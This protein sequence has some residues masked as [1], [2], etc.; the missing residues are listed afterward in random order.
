MTLGKSNDRIFLMKTYII[1][2]TQQDIDKGI[3]RTCLTCPVAIAMARAT[4][5]SITVSR[6]SFW[7][8]MRRI[9]LP[10]EAIDFIWAFDDDRKVEPFSFE[11]TIE[12]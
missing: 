7:Y 12:L 4:G 6:E 5:K 1:N 8:G 10:K 9:R 2:V 11:V 3:K